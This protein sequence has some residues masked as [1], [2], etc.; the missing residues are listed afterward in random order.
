MN[1]QKWTEK[2]LKAVERVDALAIGR[3]PTEMLSLPLLW[4]LLE[5]KNR[6]SL[7]PNELSKWE[8]R[9]QEYRVFY[10][11]DSETQSVKI[12]AIGKQEHDALFIRQ[13]EYKL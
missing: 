1:P 8:L 6:K 11:V 2:A 7:R 3:N 13:Q 12:K 9:I 10:D 5:T 4:E